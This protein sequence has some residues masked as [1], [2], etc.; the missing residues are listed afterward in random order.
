M[1]EAKREVLTAAGRITHI[2]APTE[3]N[4]MQTG[5]NQC[6]G[7]Y[8]D[9]IITANVRVP[10]PAVGFVVG[11]KGT[12]IKRIQQR[13]NTYINCPPKEDP[14]SE[15]ISMRGDAKR[16]KPERDNNVAKGNEVSVTDQTYSESESNSPRLHPRR[17]SNG[18]QRMDKRQL[19]PHSS[20]ALPSYF[21]IAKGGFGDGTPLDNSDTALQGNRGGTLDD[22]VTAAEHIRHKEP[23]FVIS[24]RPENVAEAKR[25]VLTAAECITNIPTPRENVMQNGT[26][27]CL[28]SS[29]H[30]SITINVRVPRPAAGFVVGHKGAR[31]KR[32]QQL[33]STRITSPLGEKPYFEALGKREGGERSKPEIESN[34]AKDNEWLVTN[35]A[36]GESECNSPRL[37]YHVLSNVTQ[38]KSKKDG[39]PSSSGKAEGSSSNGVLLN[40]PSLDA[41][42]EDNCGGMLESATTTTLL[43]SPFLK[44]LKQSHCFNSFNFTDSF[45]SG[46]H[47]LSTYASTT[48]NAIRQEALPKQ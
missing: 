37:H 48:S 23:I 13:T 35:H 38:L 32:I 46:T 25:R 40:D 36:H 29:V 10:R 5:S 24:G 20:V 6:L 30:K 3:I 18:S 7:P 43:S 27:Q 44:S 41:T 28:G 19:E 12:R 9:E 17:L 47:S 1:A 8:V 42:P 21:G 15:M 33:T 45:A 34:V 16:L 31:I 14:Y 4:V 26:N 22:V 11:N 2:P 39:P